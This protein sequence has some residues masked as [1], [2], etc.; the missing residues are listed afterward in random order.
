MKSFFK[1]ILLQLLP[2]WLFAQQ[3]AFYH[4]P[5]KNQYDSLVKIFPKIINDT[6]RMAA[7]HEFGF[8]LLESKRDSAFYFLDQELNLSRKFNLKLWQCDALDNSAYLLWRLGDYPGALVRFL[9]GIKIAED[10]ASEKSDWGVAR[11]S[12][13]KD[14]HIARLVFL[15]QLRF[16]LATL[17]HVAGYREKEF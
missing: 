15:A 7:Y 13:E 2:V 17:Y 8:Y 12:A 14:P 6:V 16:D 10:P 11:F 9:E 3:Y 1:T 5:D 4:F